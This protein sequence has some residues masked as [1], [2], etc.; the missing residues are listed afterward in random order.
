[1]AF[2]PERVL[3]VGEVDPIPDMDSPE[4]IKAEKRE[5]RLRC[6]GRPQENTGP[7]GKL[8]MEPRYCGSY[9]DCMGC[10]ERRAKKLRT[11]LLRPMHS[12]GVASYQEFDI[13]NT[14]G[15]AEVLAMLEQIG[16]KHY[17]RF[18]LEDASY[19]VFVDSQI[20]L[21]ENLHARV[22]SETEIHEMDWQRLARTPKGMRVSGE[23]ASTKIIEPNDG[24]ESIAFD[25]ISVYTTA[26]SE[27]REQ[28]Y[29]AAVEIDS[30]HEVPKNTVE[31]EV[32]MERR[33]NE[34]VKQLE[35]RGAKVTTSKIKVWYRIKCNRIQEEYLTFCRGK[36]YT[37]SDY[38]EN[39]T[40]WKTTV[41]MA[42]D[43]KSLDPSVQRVDGD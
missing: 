34:Y 19:K 22:V 41:D 9:R 36:Q 5:L 26:K 18:P 16:E 28:C 40:V 4:A 11:R 10:L 39:Y 31:L 33:T 8:F 29:A 35:A 6:C 2:D 15:P 1:M 20:V 23:L 25:V 21:P 13:P 38:I 14:I 3:D 7:N 42:T 30:Q 32:A 17:M 27:V 24:K 37:P 43:P 12:D